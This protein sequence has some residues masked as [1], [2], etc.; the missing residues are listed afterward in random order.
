MHAR[1][2][3]GILKQ[4]F[5]LFLKKGG[6]FIQTEI[7]SLEQRKTNE[8]AVKSENEDYKFE[9]IVVATGAFSKQFSRLS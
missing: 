6:K 8:T 7:K 3:H 5:K 2:P 4:I 9:K 1:D